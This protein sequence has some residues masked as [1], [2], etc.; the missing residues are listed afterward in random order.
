MIGRLTLILALSAFVPAC[1]QQSSSSEADSVY[2]DCLFREA[3]KL[4]RNFNT[5][6]PPD[7]ID[8]PG[9]PCAAERQVELESVRKQ[10]PNYT[11]EQANKLVDEIRNA[12]WTNI[13]KN[14]KQSY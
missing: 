14:Y 7:A 5:S 6:A 11:D 4:A 3:T 8:A 9:G 12:V 2:T 10:F 13:M 1:A